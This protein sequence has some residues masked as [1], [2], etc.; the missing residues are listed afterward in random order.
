MVEEKVVFIQVPDLEYTH[1]RLMAALIGIYEGKGLSDWVPVPL[2]FGR[3][4]KVSNAL[5]DAV[6]YLKEAFQADDLDT[7]DR[8]LKTLKLVRTSDQKNDT[9]NV[10]IAAMI[11]RG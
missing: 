6:A 7:V 5:N 3:K 1:A 2:S 8:T 4:T 11:S 10:I 9:A